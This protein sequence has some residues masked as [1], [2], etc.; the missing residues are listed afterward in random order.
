MQ[1]RS[2]SAGPRNRSSTPL[3][4]R[5]FRASF[6]AW[7]HG[8]AR[9][10]SPSLSSPNEPIRVIAAPPIR[11]DR[12]QD[13]RAGQ[14]RP[15][16]SFIRSPRHEAGIWRAPPFPQSRAGQSSAPPRNRE[17]GPTDAE[18]QKQQHRARV[19]GVEADDPVLRPWSPKDA[20]R[21]TCHGKPS[22]TC[23][24]LTDQTRIVL[25]QISPAAVVRSALL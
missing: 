5:P 8:P 15:S 19:Q 6:Q 12:R 20:E 22:R 13:R 17:C 16:T 4:G 3:R 7:A 11:S 14:G 25:M 9:R 10:S 24:V 21:A 2:G 18:R 23:A 1:H